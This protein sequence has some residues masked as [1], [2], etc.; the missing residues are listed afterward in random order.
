M[1]KLEQIAEQIHEG[2]RDHEA[3]RGRVFGSDRTDKTHPHMVPWSQLDDESRS[4]DR[5]IAAVVLHD[6]SRGNL[7]AEQL[8][9]AIHEA[10]RQWVRINGRAHHHAQPY[11][12][13]HPTGS[14][15]HALQASRIEPLLRSA[16]RTEP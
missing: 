10:W 15:E 11:E 1:D 7:T 6:W 16:A 2:W 8:P 5:F 3:R 4:Q 13:V 12:V 9:R 14:R